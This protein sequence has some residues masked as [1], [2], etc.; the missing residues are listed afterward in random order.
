M[1]DERRD[2][3]HLPIFLEIDLRY[4]PGGVL[5]L[6][7]DPL[8]PQA[9][10]QHEVRVDPSWSG[11]TALAYLLFD[12]HRLCQVARLIDLCPAGQRDAIRQ[13]L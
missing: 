10:P 2:G 11:E 12:G 8:C 13:H 1:E 5:T 7:P 9:S 3:I 6:D 4:L